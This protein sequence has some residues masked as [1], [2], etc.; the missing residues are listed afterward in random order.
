MVWQ[1]APETVGKIFLSVRSSVFGFVL[2]SLGLS[3]T[4]L[5]FL[6]DKD[7]FCLFLFS[8]LSRRVWF[9]AL[10]GRASSWRFLGV[11]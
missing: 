8:F 11:P 10:F 7:Q 2:S 1:F 9:I 3:S 5:I 4:S 6:R